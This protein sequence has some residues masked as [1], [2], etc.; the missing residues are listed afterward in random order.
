MTWSEKQ[1]AR[2]KV[3]AMV[4][5]RLFRSKESDI[6]LSK[7]SELF[8]MESLP[9]AAK[10]FTYSAFS[11][12]VGRQADLTVIKV[13]EGRRKVNVLHLDTPAAMFVGSRTGESITIDFQ[14]LRQQSNAAPLGD[15]VFH[16]SMQHEAR[17]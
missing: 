3:L 8:E 17:S 9:V 15:T 12:W 1:Q 7:L 4:M 11:N 13:Q 14:A 2:E 5:L 10:F 6:S 16:S